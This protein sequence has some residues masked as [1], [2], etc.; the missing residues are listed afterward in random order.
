MNSSK[1]SV[2][3]LLLS[4][5]FSVVDAE[6]YAVLLSL[7]AVSIRKVA[8]RSGINRGT[9]YESIKRLMNA[10]LVHARK[11]GEREYFSAESPE[12]IYELIRERRKA[13][14]D[15]QRQA[16]HIIPELL[17]SK[18]MPKGRPLVKYYEDD[19][20]M[21]SIL[22]DVLQT[23]A[24]LDE[25][26]YRVYSSR[27]LRQYLYRQF[28][29]FTE[30]R[31]QEGITV[32]AIAVGEGGEPAAMAERKWLDESSIESTATYTIIYGDK[33]AHISIAGNSMP[34]GVVIEDVGTASL[35]RTLFERVW[36]QI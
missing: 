15:T 31:V 28:P 12:K 6:T 27:L 4:L 3:A 1:T 14:M 33:V 9:T 19:D 26:I 32:K 22:K 10:G 30:R 20:G 35:Q 7:D 17:A 18:A 11:S 8:A 21:V 29:Q 36:S 13:L 24:Q 2:Q 23:C 16:Q 25:P 34:Y 5:G